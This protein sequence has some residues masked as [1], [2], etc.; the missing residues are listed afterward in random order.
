LAI[1]INVVKTRLHRA[2]SAL[3]GLLDPELERLN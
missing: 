3:K 1:Q 2:R